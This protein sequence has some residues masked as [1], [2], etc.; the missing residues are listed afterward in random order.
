MCK[1]LI[2]VHCFISL[3]ILWEAYQYQG[4]VREYTILMWLQMDNEIVFVS[5]RK[6]LQWISLPKFLFLQRYWIERYE[7]I[8]GF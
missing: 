2:F 6:M 8:Y 5:I 3:L 4:I 1:T 7:R